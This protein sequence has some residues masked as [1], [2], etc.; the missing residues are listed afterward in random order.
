MRTLSSN[1]HNHSIRH[2]SVPMPPMRFTRG[3]EI[4][5]LPRLQTRVRTERFPYRPDKRKG[6]RGRHGCSGSRYGVVVVEKGEVS[7][8]MVIRV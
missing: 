6:A 1:L 3:P 7:L 4:V 2:R 5:Y 8:D